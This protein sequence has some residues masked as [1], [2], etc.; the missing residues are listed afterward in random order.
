MNE[1][2]TGKCLKQVDY[3]L[4]HLWQMFFMVKFEEN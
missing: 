3:I 4:G 2:S 1:D